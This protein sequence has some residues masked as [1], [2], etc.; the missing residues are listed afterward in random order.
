VP[1]T[2]DGFIEHE[3]IT[4]GGTLVRTDIVNRV[5]FAAFEKNGD[6]HAFDVDGQPP[7]LDDLADLR[8]CLKAFRGQDLSLQSRHRPRTTDMA[9]GF[10]ATSC[11]DPT[12]SS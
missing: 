9:D 3:S 10:A 4:Q 6:R 11:G 7:T 8:D 2:G 12:Y 5:I 1:G